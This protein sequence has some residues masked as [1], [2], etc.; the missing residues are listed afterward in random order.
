MPK[1]K[2]KAPRKRGEISPKVA[3]MIQG[4]NDLCDA[5][6]QGIPLEQRFTVHTWKLD[7][8][9]RAYTGDDVRRIRELLG[10]SQP[11]FA[12]FLGVNPGTVRSWEQGTRTTSGMARRFLEEIE[13]DPEHWRK[14]LGERAERC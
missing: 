5:I 9:P 8:T 11:V 4:M 14:R 13:R 10:M 6:E 12:R 3:A 7:L 2:P 1:M